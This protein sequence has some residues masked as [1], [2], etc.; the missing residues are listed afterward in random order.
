[1]VEEKKKGNIIDRTYYPIDFNN[2]RHS[3]FIN[4]FALS[5]LLK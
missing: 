2:G 3:D 4:E 1:M 5:I